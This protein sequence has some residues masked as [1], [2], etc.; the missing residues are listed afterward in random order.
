MNKRCHKILQD[1]S[2]VIWTDQIFMQWSMLK[3]SG[4]RKD[5]SQSSG[6]EAALQMSWSYFR[7]MYLYTPV[8]PP[9]LRNYRCV[10][11]SCRHVLGKCLRQ[12]LSCMIY[13]CQFRIGLQHQQ[14]L[15]LTVNYFHCPKVHVVG[16][17]SDYRPLLRNNSCHLLST[18]YAEGQF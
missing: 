10:S 5:I 2:S 12:H 18:T 7:C 1:S 9:P 3:A 4:R 15:Q 14:Y 8:I 11:C 17:H 13:W 6:S 16:M